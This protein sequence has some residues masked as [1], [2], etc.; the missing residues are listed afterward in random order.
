[1]ILFVKVFSQIIF[2]L[3]DR[4]LLM[5]EQ[6]SIPVGH[7][8]I[9]IRQQP[10]SQ[11]LLITLDPTVRQ[12]VFSGP[13]YILLVVFR[14]LVKAFPSVSAFCE[15]IFNFCPS[16]SFTITNLFPVIFMKIVFL[17]IYLRYPQAKCS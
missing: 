5:R 8:L 17:K 3:T 6:L 2:V 1:M 12:M 10:T 4:L 14:S 13:C 16:E 11:Q 15:P 9:G 7:W